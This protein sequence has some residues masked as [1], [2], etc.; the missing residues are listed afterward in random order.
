MSTSVIETQ[1][2]H[3]T[4]GARI[5]FRFVFIYF[6]IQCVPVFDWRYWHLVFSINWLSLRY[7]DIF[8]LAHYQSS[9]FTD[10]QNFTNWLV[11]AIIA[12][13]GAGIWTNI[14]KEKTNNYDR[15]YYWLRVIVRY[16]L[17]I[18][19]IAYGFI[20][21][22]PLQSPYPS[23]SNLNT[24][25]GDFTRW[26]LFSLSLGVVPHY[27]LFLGL[28]EIVAGLLLFYRKTASIGALIVLFFTG[29]V[30]MS[31]LAYEGGEYVY[32][33]YLIV[34]ALFTLVYDAQRLGSL[35][36]WQRTTSP[37]RFKISFSGKEKYIRWILKM[38][39][40]FFFVVLYA[41]KTGYG[42]KHDPYQI[43]LSKGLSGVSGIYDVNLFIINHDT[44]PYSKTDSIRWQ[45]V[46]FE[47]WATLS[48]RTNMPV[49]IDSS[50]VE[51]LGAK[52]DIN[53][54]YEAEGTN[55]RSYYAYK[56]DTVNH[57]L[58]LLNKNPHYKNDS[59]VLN[60]QHPDSSQLV[61]S[62]VDQ[63]RDTVYVVLNRIDKKY[64]IE[65]AGKRGRFGGFKL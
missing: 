64:L 11:V 6:I 31:N 23:I 29:N 5:A 28:V 26:K 55:E 10:A 54:T 32:S 14:D 21:F 41:F 17:A 44:I 57:V 45:D 15:L 13:L 42:Y 65:E 22:F 2:T 37:N 3:W 48:I 9:F 46:V 36:I 12:L 40:I 60:Y 53:R 51:K 35:F 25:Y 20:K 61:L 1:Q 24:N 58:T 18:G 43:P 34:L 39:V 47:K 50:N 33:F 27:E 62:G 16:R 59:L 38:F 4:Q 52:E 7:E 19:I 30:F 8:N 56:A 63:Y 49:I